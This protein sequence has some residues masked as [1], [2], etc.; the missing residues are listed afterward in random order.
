ME[1]GAV[2]T[3][4]AGYSLRMHLLCGSCGREHALTT[5]LRPMTEETP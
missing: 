3:L 1:P 4:A 2:E 5:T